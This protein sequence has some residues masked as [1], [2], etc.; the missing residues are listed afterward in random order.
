PTAAHRGDDAA[1]VHRGHRW[2]GGRPEDPRVAQRPSL[3]VED[4]GVQGTGG[5]DRGEIERFLGKLD[6]HALL[7]KEGNRV[8]RWREARRTDE[9]ERERRDPMLH[10]TSV[11]PAGG[12][13]TGKCRG[14]SGPRRRQRRGR[15]ATG[16]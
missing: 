14:Y 15:R 11:A 3:G 6:A 5:A 13:F 4:G 16:E 8:G 10:P 12:R 2:I 7:G 1:V 9:G